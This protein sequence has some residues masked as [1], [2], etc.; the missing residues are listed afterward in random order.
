MNW[1]TLE[2]GEKSAKLPP[3][4]CSV[5]SPRLPNFRCAMIY[6]RNLFSVGKQNAYIFNSLCHHYHGKVSNTIDTRWFYLWTSILSKFITHA[7]FYCLL[8]RGQ[9]QYN[10]SLCQGLV[11]LHVLCKTGENRHKRLILTIRDHSWSKWLNYTAIYDKQ[12]TL[13]KRNVH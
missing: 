13:T 6:G 11:Q 1:E 4:Y 12:K 3:F 10:C 9:I 5:T 8:K 2:A 7:E